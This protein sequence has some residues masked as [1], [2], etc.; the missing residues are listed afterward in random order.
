MIQNKI[1]IF[2]QFQT[3]DRWRV[4]SLGQFF[5]VKIWPA[6]N[7]LLSVAELQLLWEDKVGHHD[8]DDVGDDD[9][10]DDD[11]YDDD[12]DDDNDD[13]DNDDDDDDD[14]QDQDYDQEHHCH[15][16]ITL[17]S[18]LMLTIKA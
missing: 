3:E 7:D 11:D 17:H 4:L 5:F 15:Q 8:D 16:L 1:L 18:T 10:D 12:Y 6:N 13:D 2:F 14:E 9:D